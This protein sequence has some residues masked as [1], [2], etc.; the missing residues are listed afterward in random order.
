MR[1]HVR[2]IKFEIIDGRFSPIDT[3][4]ITDEMMDAVIAAEMPKQEVSEASNEVDDTESLKDGDTVEIVSDTDEDDT[5]LLCGFLRCEHSVLQFYPDYLTYVKAVSP[6]EVNRKTTSQ[7]RTIEWGT[8]II[9]ELN[10][11]FSSTDATVTYDGYFLVDVWKVANEAYFC[12]SAM[13]SGRSRC[14]RAN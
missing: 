2:E 14:S 5:K 9:D 8:R 13:P 6:S 1:F 10:D 7:R 4:I 11:A 3:W 12:D